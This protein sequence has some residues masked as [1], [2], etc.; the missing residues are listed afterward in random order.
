MSKIADFFKIGN[1]KM[2]DVDLYMYYLE[3]YKTLK[4][5]NPVNLRF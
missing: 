3:D 4:D 5:N 2:H 1:H